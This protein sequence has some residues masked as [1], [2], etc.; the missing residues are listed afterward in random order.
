MEPWLNP[1]VRHF[2]KPDLKVDQWNNVASLFAEL[3]K[4]L[5]ENLADLKKWLA[6]WSE[7][8][9]IVG[10]EGTHREIAMTC[11]TEDDAIKKKYLDYVD[12]IQPEFKKAHF[13]LCKKYLASPLQGQLGVKYHQLNLYFSNQVHLFKEE[14]L[15]LESEIANLGQQ[16]QELTGSWM[17]HFEGKERTLPEM[18]VYLQSENRSVREA[19]FLTVGGRRLQDKEKL[20]QLF[21]TL[22]SK[23]KQVAKNLGFRDFRDYIF[24]KKLREYTP[25]DCYKFHASVEK[26]VVPLVSK[27]RDERGKLMKLPSLKP[28]DLSCDPLGR[29]PLKPFL[30]VAELQD[31]VE[32]IF[33]RIDWQLKKYFHSIRPYQDL[34]SRK[35]KAPGGYQATFDEQCI[36]FIFTNAAG[37]QDDVETLLHEGGHAFHT[38]Q[39]RNQPL[40]W[41]RDAP[42]EFCEVASMSQ[43]L[44]GGSHFGV[45]Y[46]LE[47][48]AKRARKLHL[49]SVLEVFPWVM[50]VDAFQH[51]IY[52]HDNPTHQER[53]EA[54]VK[55]QT[56]FETAV[57][58]S[59][60]DPDF[61]RTLW[62]KQLHIFLEPFYYIEYAIS[63]LGALQ[64]FRNYKKNPKKTLDQFLSAMRLGRSK[65]CKEIYKHAAIEFRFDEPFV[66]E[67]AEM[68]FEEIKMIA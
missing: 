19:A 33:G 18:M 46:P 1:P 47:E 34:D 17:V 45:F 28:W 11:A 9:S 64:I 30:K 10:E 24:K 31:G 6:D 61:K 65:S 20:D 16:Y 39:V 37:L 26:S 23:R 68:V 15:K 42:M 58:W 57:D 22:T 4:R 2:A 51:W 32:E 56:R 36:P 12:H 55:E 3:Q 62:H 44:L 41:Y 14:N 29:K 60:L 38:L 49:E 43:E 48:E 27:L 63:Q 40:Y 25:E 52:T 7:L 54:W 50:T 35:G 5:L 53:A 67:L 8:E 66:K 59:G 13:E 21:D